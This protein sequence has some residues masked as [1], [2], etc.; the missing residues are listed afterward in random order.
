MRALF[1]SLEKNIS[2]IQKKL[3]SVLQKKLGD[4]PGFIV[5]GDPG[6]IKEIQQ[7]VDNNIYIVGKKRCPVCAATFGKDD[8]KMHHFPYC[9]V[10]KIKL[11]K[12]ETSM[13]LE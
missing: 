10:P 12:I 4:V 5:E 9:W 8:Q 3:A 13:K 11:L 7:W 1:P 2:E 6:L